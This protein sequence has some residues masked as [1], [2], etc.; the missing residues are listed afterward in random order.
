MKRHGK[1]E[2]KR[3]GWI[4]SPLFDLLFFA[5]L[6]WPLAFLPSYVS[7]DG[8]PYLEFWQIHFIATPH[9]WLTLLLVATDVDRRS[10]RTWLFVVIAVVVAAVMAGVQITTG[11]LAAL[12]LA[13]YC[14]NSWHFASQHS[15]ILRIYARKS[16]GA[17][18]W[19]DTYLLR[20]FVL[21]ASLRVFPG[22]DYLL[23]SVWLDVAWFDYVMLATA[24]GMV[25]AEI[26][27]PSDHRLP[28]LCYLVSVCGIYSSVIVAA[29]NQQTSL[30]VALVVATTI[31]HSVEYFA[32]VTHYAWRRQE[33]GSAGIFQ[34]V[35]QHWLMVLSWYLVVLGVIVG[36]GERYLNTAFVA[37]NM[38]ASFLHFAYDG[39]IWKLRQP[40]TAK[41]LDAEST[42]AAD[43]EVSS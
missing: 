6:L 38:W 28:K 8:T 25:V 26:L 3:S 17:H 37:V 21:Y 22:F 23:A 39:L 41:I 19:I 40:S 14:W 12:G 35:A 27:G 5:N 42:G 11:S 43:D 34:H 29:H 13:Y 1:L 15:G 4:V 10:G 33:H 32:I 31:F 7:P 30:L 20:G 9:R 16:G 36:T 2:D 18:R 24:A